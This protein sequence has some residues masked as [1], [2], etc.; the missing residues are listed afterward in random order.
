MDFK[1]YFSGHAALYAQYRPDYPKA[2][3]DYLATLPKERHLAWDVATG[4]GQVAVDLADYFEQVVATDASAEQIHYA[5]QH[6]TNVRYVV[7]PAEK[8]SLTAQSVDLITV[9]QAAHWFDL[10]EFYAEVKRVVKPGGILALWCYAT[11]IISE[12]KITPLLDILYEKITG[13]F[14]PKERQLIDQHYQT[15]DFPFTKLATPALQIE[16]NWTLSEFLGY[17]S[18]WSGLQIAY[19]KGEQ[20]AIEENFL[21]IK[22]AWG[23]PESKKLISWP[24]YFL[25]TRF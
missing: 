22:T 4:S 25:V 24:I 11:P 8:T 9:G 6:K 10:K 12:D 1:D 14:W 17:L 19:K 18:T 2:L 5:D 16:K 20:Q 15:L 13:Q 3:F 7:E 21:A 23:A